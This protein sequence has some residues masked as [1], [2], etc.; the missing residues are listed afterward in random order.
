MTTDFG[1]WVLKACIDKNTT[2]KEIAEAIGVSAMEISF[3][4][5]GKRQ[6]G[7]IEAEIKRYLESLPDA[8]K[9]SDFEK[10]MR[11][12][13]IDKDIKLSQLAKIMGIS[14]AAIYYAVAGK[15]GYD[16]IREKMVAYIDKM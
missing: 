16:K 13:L 6:S 11:C 7:F 15:A 5:R 2:A 8:C 10:D 3:I 1:K 12:K 4:I 9:M 14:R